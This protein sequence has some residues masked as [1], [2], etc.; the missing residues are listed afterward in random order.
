[1][2][3]FTN[4]IPEYGIHDK[5]FPDEI[6]RRIWSFLKAMLESMIGVDA[7]CII[8]GEAVL[9]ELI[10]ELLQEYPDDIKICFLGFT[11]VDVDKKFKEIRKYSSEKN[12]WLA[13]ES[14]AYVKDHVKNMITHSSDIKISC[15]KYNLKYFDTSKSFT[16]TIDDA[17]KYL[18]A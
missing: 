4:G 6:A 7:D 13:D 15:K 12:D 3:G 11:D 9:P 1:M 5:L 14:D 17:V 8:E 2:M 16:D 10:M 18:S